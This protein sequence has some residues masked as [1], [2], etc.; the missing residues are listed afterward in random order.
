MWIWIA[1]PTQIVG[2]R[3][4]REATRGA[5]LDR[6]TKAMGRRLPV[7]IVE[8]N[9]R[10]HDPVQAAKFA[11]QASVIV[12]GQVPILTHWKEYKQHT[13]HFDG[14]VGKLS[15]SAYPLVPLLH[16]TLI[17]P[18]CNSDANYQG[19]LAID[20]SHKPTKDACVSVFQSAIRQR[21]YRLKKKYLLAA[22]LMRSPQ[23]LLSPTWLMHSG[24][25]LLIS[26]QICATG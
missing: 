11:S 15:V 14:F 2:L 16:W 3:K 20:Q 26:G 19:R 4:A 17:W 13:K 7:T 18:S 23:P 5:I 9:L 1:A 24:L 6:M 10:P 25:N 12:R 21:W 22:M 8:G